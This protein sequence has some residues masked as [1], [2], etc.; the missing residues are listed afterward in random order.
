MERQI[1][2]FHDPRMSSTKIQ[3]I[4]Q[5]L[6]KIL[7]QAFKHKNF[8]QGLLNAIAHLK[9]ELA[10]HFPPQP[11]TS[12]ENFLPNKIIWQEDSKNI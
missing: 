4:D 11:S 7:Q 5:D 10:P 9:K 6:L 1:V 12:S 3:Q 8:Q 2:I